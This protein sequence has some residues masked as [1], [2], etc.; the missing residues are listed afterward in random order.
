MIFP[1]ESVPNVV[2]NMA[3]WDSRSAVGA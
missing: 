2:H 1:S 3:R